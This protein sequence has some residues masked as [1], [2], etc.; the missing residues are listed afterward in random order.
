MRCYRQWIQTVARNEYKYYY[1]TGLETVFFSPGP[2]GPLL[3][4]TLGPKQKF[5]G[6]NMYMYVGGSK[7]VEAIWAPELENRGSFGKTRG[8][9]PLGP[10]D[11]RALM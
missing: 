9:W 10:R 2:F 5:G 11:F 1:V 7:K 6:P 3:L 4:K 8:L